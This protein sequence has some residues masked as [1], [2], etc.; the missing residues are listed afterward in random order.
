MYWDFWLPAISI[1][2][3]Y[4]CPRIMCRRSKLLGK[5]KLPKPSEMMVMSWNPLSTVGK[6]SFYG[7]ISP[8][9]AMGTAR[10]YSSS[11]VNVDCPMASLRGHS[12][13]LPP[14]KKKGCYGF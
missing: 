11:S 4:P 3:A 13:Q 12:G 7:N 2:G 6:I 1:E 5:M 10:L 14:P 9:L 8:A